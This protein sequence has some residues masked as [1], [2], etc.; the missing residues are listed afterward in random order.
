MKLADLLAHAS[1]LLA[2]GVPPDADVVAQ[3][4]EGDFHGLLFDRVI[5]ADFAYHPSRNEWVRIAPEMPTPE[6]W[7]RKRAVLL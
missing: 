7:D 2:E 3:N 1:K 4:H 6:G 5:V